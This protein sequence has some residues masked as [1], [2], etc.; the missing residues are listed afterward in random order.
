M[1]VYASENNINYTPIP[2][3]SGSSSNSSTTTS[4]NN[5]FT[6]AV[7][8]AGGAASALAWLI[9]NFNEFANTATLLANAGA[10]NTATTILSQD[11]FKAA[12]GTAQ[13][14][15]ADI[16]VPVIM[17]LTGMTA[18]GALWYTLSN[19]APQKENM[20]S[21]VTTSEKTAMVAT[22][23]GLST[24]DLVRSQWLDG[25]ITYYDY[26][27]FCL[28]SGR[29]VIPPHVGKSVLL[30][31][32]L[33]VSQTMGITKSDYLNNL[34]GLREYPLLDVEKRGGKEY[35]C[36]NPEI[37]GDYNPKTNEIRI[38][39]ASMKQEEV[40]YLK[41]TVMNSQ[42]HETNHWKR[43]VE[44]DDIFKIAKMKGYFNVYTKNSD[45][46]SRE[47]T[48]LRRLEELLND[49]Q[50]YKYFKDFVGN[51]LPP[52]MNDWLSNGNIY[53]TNKQVL[54]EMSVSRDEAV[55]YIERSTTAKANLVNKALYLIDGSMPAIIGLVSAAT[56]GNA[57]LRKDLTL[58]QAARNTIID[59][60]SG[61][62]MYYMMTLEG[63]GPLVGLADLGATL[64][65]VREFACD[66][67]DLGNIEIVAQDTPCAKTSSA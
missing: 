14:L 16:A 38:N 66:Y 48:L 47:G 60:G 24:T 21:E 29:S 28:D 50:T 37:G 52:Q 67:T 42:R 18:A 53:A 64:P 11:V 39:T 41:Q 40:D 9:A 17:G 23:G 59:T 6:P 10:M 44:G 45:L 32:Q 19:K 3:S 20:A 22:L 1:T 56:N 33:E 62:A 8:A 15:P 5:W 43:V 31:N 49:R 30:Q 58:E 2:S 12:V 57:Y 13:S 36:Y 25:Y 61:T 51:Y 34:N 35:E 7:I 54:D 4:S 63:A 46:E 65:P 27:N 26:N 55:S